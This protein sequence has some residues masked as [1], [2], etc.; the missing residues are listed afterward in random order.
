MWILLAINRQLIR[1]ER[2]LEDLG[3]TCLA[4]EVV[5]FRLIKYRLFWVRK[6]PK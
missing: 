4:E 1:L 6:L 2:L 3:L 5:V